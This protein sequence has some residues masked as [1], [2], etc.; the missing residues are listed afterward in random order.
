MGVGVDV[1]DAVLDCVPLPLRVRV[2]VTVA[3]RDAVTLLVDVRVSVLDGE[4]VADADSDALCVPVAVA[5]CVRVPVRVAVAVM[6]ADR[7]RVVPSDFGWNDV[8]HWAALAD[9]GEADAEGNVRAGADTPDRPVLFVDA[10]GNI[11][12]R[13]SDRL[14][15]LVGV[16]D[17]VVVDTPDALLVCHR[18]QAQE[19]RK[20]VARLEAL[21]LEAL[22]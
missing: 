6:D 20:V 8:G 9:F 13:E 11:V 15:A 21:K 5:V 3:L 18:D 12:Q 1:S 14:V 2:P 22:L 17:L 7:V 19:V 16:R 10:H 4:S